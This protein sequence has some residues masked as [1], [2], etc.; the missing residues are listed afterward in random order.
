MWKWVL[1]TL[2]WASLQAAEA[3]F[4]KS[5]AKVYER[6][7]NGEIIVA[8][9]ARENATSP[10][11][12]LRLNGGGQVMVPREFVYTQAQ[13]YDQ[14]PRASEHVK[15]IS[16]DAE[17]HR[18]T[19]DL[20]AL[21][22]RMRFVVEVRANRD[23]DPWR[24]EYRVVG[25]PF[26]GLTGQVGFADLGQKTEVGFSGEYKYDRL[27]VPQKFLEFGMEV[28]LQ[29]MAARLRAFVTEEWKKNKSGSVAS[30]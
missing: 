4:W 2:T 17:K 29:R 25:G 26:V 23:V 18:V 3:P 7:Q 21:G 5:K 9:S 27:P 16:Y 22:N 14:F 8:V 28:V 19:M 30:P 15:S 20:E 11:R 6:V 1:W 10:R 12:T 24:L 13:K